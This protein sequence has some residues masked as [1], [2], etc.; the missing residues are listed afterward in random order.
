MDLTNASG[1]EPVTI[2]DT[3][4][5]QLKMRDLAAL[6]VKL[7]KLMRDEVVARLDAA[8]V[9]DSFD[10]LT[11]LQK[12]DNMP[13][14]RSDGVRWCRNPGGVAETLEAAMARAGVE[15]DADDLLARSGASHDDAA[16]AALALWGFRIEPRGD[17]A[18][19]GGASDDEDP[20]ARTPPT[21]G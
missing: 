21:G 17:D 10:R 4:L 5:P 3:D 18:G 13:L 6:L 9:T 1:V 20:L 12:F 2:G 11:E 19:E 15:G 16:I 8:G 14:G 7:R